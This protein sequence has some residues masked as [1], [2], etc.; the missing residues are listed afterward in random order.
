MLS[1]GNVPGT[2]PERATPYRWTAVDNYRR[3]LL[4]KW[5]IIKPLHFL[6]FLH[7]SPK[8]EKGGLC[9]KCRKCN[10]LIH[11]FIPFLIGSVLDMPEETAF[12]PVLEC[13]LAYLVRLGNLHA[14]AGFEGNRQFVVDGTLLLRET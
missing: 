14:L 7:F 6:H 2:S 1:V 8:A 3:L 4:Y 11:L 9:G 5:I 13:S 12:E 10:G